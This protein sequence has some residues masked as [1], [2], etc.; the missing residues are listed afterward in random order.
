MK[1]K[2]LT[3]NQLLEAAF[4]L[5]ANHGI[6]KTS[7]AMIANEVG[8]TKPSIYYHFSSKEELVQRVFDHIFSDYKFAHYFPIEQFHAHNFGEL[9]YQGGLRM[10]PE[11]HEENYAALRLVNEFMLSAGRQENYAQRLIHMQQE[12]L[13]GFHELLQKGANLGVVSSTHLEPK[14]HMLALVID[15]ITTYMMMQ[16]ELNYEQI[17]QE[18]V[19]HVLLSGR[20]QR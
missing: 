16:L 17:W 4:E 15:N 19:N 5:F 20:D 3:T 6:E 10:I 8:I 2:E 9:L 7:L 12:F 1:K 18:A 14:A 11:P 13:D